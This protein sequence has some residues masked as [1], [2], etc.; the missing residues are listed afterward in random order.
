MSSQLILD[1]IRH[2]K[3]VW[4]YRVMRD[5]DQLPFY[6]VMNSVNAPTV[7]VEGRECVM[8]GSNNYLG[9]ADH[10]KVRESAM[11]ALRKYGTTVT[12]SRLLNGTIDLHVQL[13]AELAAWHGTKNALLFTTGYQANLGAISALVGVG[14]T[15]IVDSAAHASIYD[16]ARLSRAKIR[17]FRHN[18]AAQLDE[19]LSRSV[20]AKLVIVDGLYSMEGDLAPL[21]A[22]ADVCEKHDA[23]LM[24]DEAHSVGVLGERRTGAAE[25]YGVEKRIDVRMG[26]LSKGLGSTGG[27]VCG[28]RDIVDALRAHARTFLFTTAAVPA[29]LGAALA[30]VR[31]LQTDEGRER[32]TR[33][34]ENA[35]YLRDG[36]VA[37]GIP[38]VE[39]SPLPDGTEV[40]SPI[41]PAFCYTELRVSNTWRKLYDEGVFAAVAM[42]P[43][44]PQ[45]KAM[46]RLC[47]QTEHTHSQLDR[48]IDALVR[49]LPPMDFTETDATNYAA[50][51]VGSAEA[52]GMDDPE[53]IDAASELANE[54][55][56]ASALG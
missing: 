14:D 4:A 24:V 29:T 26:S 2:D 48:A 21:D 18:N 44:V 41:V 54:R 3:R 22:I 9:M 1:R 23:A 19:R 42:F 45:N 52:A 36:L 13:E 37:A 50:G 31:M 17:A 46:L 11:A 20:G 40:V 55:V 16:A 6:R 30:S 25:L 51:A 49:H 7:P 38:T 34:L 28:N 15:V 12:G 56:P 43:A 32:G 5:S 10:P 39:P 33:T 53:D 27:F 8:L 47:V 35:K